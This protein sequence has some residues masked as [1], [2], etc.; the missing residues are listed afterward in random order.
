MSMSA[1]FY[2]SSDHDQIWCYETR[3]YLIFSR[4]AL[5]SKVIK[6]PSPLFLRRVLCRTL[7]GLRFPGIGEFY[8]LLKNEETIL[9][10]SPLELSFMAS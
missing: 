10:N 2:V 9:T 1:S 8:V 5:V 4:F 3:V 6:T 7:Q